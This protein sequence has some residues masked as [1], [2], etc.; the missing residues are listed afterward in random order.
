[1]KGEDGYSGACNTQFRINCP[2]SAKHGRDAGYVSKQ[3][4]HSSDAF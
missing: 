2:T 3:T 1:M 4:F